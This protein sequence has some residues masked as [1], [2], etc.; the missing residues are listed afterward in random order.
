MPVSPDNPLGILMEPTE[1][2]CLAARDAARTQDKPAVKQLP[3]RL[4]WFNA[5][6]GIWL[7]Q[8]DCLTF[9]DR[10]AE[11][12]P[13]GRFDM[14]FADPPYF[15]SNGGITCHA[16]RMV[17]VNKGDWDK[18]RGAEENHELNR[19][20]LE[21]CRRVLRQDGTIWVSGTAHVIHSVG[22]AMQQLGFKL[23]NDIVWLKPNPPPNLSCRYFTHTTETLIWAA[24]SSSSKHHFDYQLMRKLAGGR[25]MKSYWPDVKEDKVV[26]TGLLEIPPPGRDEKQYG[27]HPT[28]KP[29]AL[30]ERIILASTQEGALILDPFMGSGTTGVAAVRLHRMFVGVELVEQYVHTASRRIADELKHSDQLKVGI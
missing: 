13:D 1:V 9:M 7:Y 23:L 26:P 8:A 2:T 19:Q 18:S 30:L 25:Q 28:Q 10:V 17:S 6:A 29:V 5:K 14:I 4:H 3:F 11:A 22:Y 24:K 21:R 16:G 12:H 27:K 15:L 20:W